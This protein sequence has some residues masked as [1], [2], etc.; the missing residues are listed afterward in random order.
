MKKF[1]YLFGLIVLSTVT[2]G[3]E[4]PG[5][6]FERYVSLS[7]S[8]D[9]AVV[10]LYADDARII[11]YRRYPHGLERRMELTGTEWKELLRKIMPVARLR[12]DRSTYSNIRIT[13]EAGAYRIKADRYSMQ[14]CYTDKGY[15][16][17]VAAQ[18]DGTLQI[19]EEYSETQP[20]SE[21]YP[22]L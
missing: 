9:Q 19:V 6:F 11:G 13:A 15:Y 3:A 20:Q 16:M 21:C 4:Q 14:K 17:R 12:N 2:F 10:D 8:F 1:V 18:P 7:S 5:E 22:R